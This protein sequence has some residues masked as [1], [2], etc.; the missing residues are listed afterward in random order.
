MSQQTFADVVRDTH[1][2]KD[3]LRWERQQRSKRRKLEPAAIPAGP[4]CARCTHWLLPTGGD[5]GECRVALVVTKGRAKGVVMTITE[6]EA[7]V[8]SMRDVEV[9]EPLSTAPHFTCS[10]F[11]DQTTSLATETSA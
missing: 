7:R 2:S 10:Q 1:K 11:A 3:E 8:Y 5:R 9:I 4:C 6:H